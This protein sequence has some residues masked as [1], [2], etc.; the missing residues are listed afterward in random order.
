MVARYPPNGAKDCT[1]ANA[2]AKVVEFPAPYGAVIDIYNTGDT[3]D[4]TYKI[5]GYRSMSPLAT[6]KT[7]TSDTVVGEGANATNV[8]VSTSFSLV[9]VWVKSTAEGAATTGQVEWITP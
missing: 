9:Q 5:I 3:N 4:L 1:T 8:D 2:Y 7:I 6:A